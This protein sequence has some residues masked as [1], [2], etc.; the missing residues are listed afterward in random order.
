MPWQTWEGVE[1]N[2]R[3]DHSCLN[4]NF[5][6]SPSRW[7]RPKSFFDHNNSNSPFPVTADTSVIHNAVYNPVGPITNPWNPS[8]DLRND[9]GGDPNPTSGQRD[10]VR[11]SQRQ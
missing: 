6:Q 9:G 11:Q 3:I 7:A 8:G 5:P 1:N 10:I 4:Y 2:R